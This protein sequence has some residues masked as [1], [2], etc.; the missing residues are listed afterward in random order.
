MP[1]KQ[2]HKGTTIPLTPAERDA[3]EKIYRKYVKD[4]ILYVYKL[5]HNKEE[6]HEIAQQAFFKLLENRQDLEIIPSVLPWLCLVSLNI[7]RDKYRH[8]KVISKAE[9]DPSLIPENEPAYE[10]IDL[11]IKVFEKIDRAVAGMSLNYR[12]VYELSFV[13]GL[14][15]EK[16]ASELGVSNEVVRTRKTEILKTLRNIF[17]D[18]EIFR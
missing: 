5:T 4:L 18:K 8:N 3:F 10:N 1:K 9:K 12:Q 11:K 15:N 2:K 13:Q 14:S 7:Y 17:P 16:V 6:A